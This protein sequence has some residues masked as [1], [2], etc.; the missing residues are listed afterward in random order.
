[1]KINFEHTDTYGG[2]SN[3]SW[4]R[5]HA[6]ELPDTTSDLALVRKAKAWANLTGLSCRVESYGDMIAIYPRG[7]CHVVFVTFGE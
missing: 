7:V 3:Y 2:E 6:L 5:R 4:V 1:M